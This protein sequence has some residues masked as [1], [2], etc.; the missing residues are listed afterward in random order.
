MNEIGDKSEDEK[1]IERNFP[2][3]QM[4]K[5]KQY[6]LDDNV[7]EIMLNADG[8]IRIEDNIKKYKT[9]IFLSDDEAMS[10]ITAVASE[11][12]K[13]MSRDTGGIISGILATGDRFEGINGEASG[14][15]TIFCI[16]KKARKIY[17][18]DDY[19]ESQIISEAEKDYIIEKIKERKNV[20]IIG[21]T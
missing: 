16:R 11:N 12:N 5:I 21:G 10:I 8:Y 4:R 13:E 9:D 18:L 1:I 19:V 3:Q 7:T 17:T 6:L 15:K 2:L 20:L 14:H